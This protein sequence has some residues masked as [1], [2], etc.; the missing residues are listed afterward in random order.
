MLMSSCVSLDASRQWVKR[1]DAGQNTLPGSAFVKVL[2]KSSETFFT[3]PPVLRFA[4]HVCLVNVG[5]G[6]H[7]CAGAVVCVR[8]QQGCFPPTNVY[9]AD[10]GIHVRMDA[11]PA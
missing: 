3:S 2:L 1:R 5:R 4:T 7:R 11:V 10:A 8:R 6:D 9:R